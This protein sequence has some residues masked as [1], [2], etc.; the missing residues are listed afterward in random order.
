MELLE[1]VPI[2]RMALM[3]ISSFAR[4]VS[5]MDAKM[6][7]WFSKIVLLKRS[8]ES[9]MLCKASCAR[10]CHCAYLDTSVLGLP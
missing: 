3:T 1:L 2:S 6:V 9:A 7:F 4:R 10:F 5:L 8:K